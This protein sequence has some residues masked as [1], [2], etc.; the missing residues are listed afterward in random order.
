MFPFCFTLGAAYVFLGFFFN[1]S[2]A[3]HTCKIKWV[4][5]IDFAHDVFMIWMSHTHLHIPLSLNNIY[6]VTNWM[7]MEYYNGSILDVQWPQ[8]YLNLPNHE[9]FGRILGSPVYTYPAHAHLVFIW[10]QT[11]KF[12]CSSLCLYYQF[13]SWDKNVWV[14]KRKL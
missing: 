5:N 6:F 9:N 1:I 14:W 13:Q 12:W 10:L 2:S 11:I 7:L 3:Y 4:C 8:P